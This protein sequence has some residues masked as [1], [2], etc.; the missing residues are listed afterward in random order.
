MSVG[1]GAMEWWPSMVRH[2]VSLHGRSKKEVQT[3]YKV[4]F[5]VCSKRE[6]SKSEVHVRGLDGACQAGLM[7]VLA[8]KCLPP[9]AETA[10]CEDGA[11]VLH[12]RVAL[13]LNSHKVSSRVLRNALQQDTQGVFQGACQDDPNMA[14]RGPQQ[15][16]GGA[17]V[18]PKEFKRVSRGPREWRK[19]VPRGYQEGP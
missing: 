3:F 10:A 8:G 18:G 19:R 5:F 1:R 2:G 6:S 12:E 4:I 7:K 9:S 13:R 17:R 16:P 11:P 15:S 14:S